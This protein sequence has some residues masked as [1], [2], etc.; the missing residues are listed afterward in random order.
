MTQVLL[1]GRDAEHNTTGIG[2]G[3]QIRMGD[4]GRYLSAGPHTYRIRYRTTGH[5]R[6]GDVYDGLYLNVVS[7]DFGL[8][9][10]KASCTLVLPGAARV[11][12]G[13]NSCYSGARVAAPGLHAARRRRG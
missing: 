2:N 10:Q 11:P 8:P 4:A 1:D 7:N 3:I 12:D 9:I 6:E 13:A 5:I